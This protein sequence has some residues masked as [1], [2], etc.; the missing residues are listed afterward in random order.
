A[1]SARAHGLA[2][3]PAVEYGSARNV[4][5]FVNGRAVRD[6]SLTHAVLR[7]YGELMPHGRYPGAIVFLEVPPAALDVNVHPPQA[8]GRRAHRRAAWDAI[9]SGLTQVLARGDWIQQRQGTGAV[10]VQ[11][12]AEAIERY[13]VR[14]PATWWMPPAHGSQDA[15]TAP[16]FAPAAEPTGQP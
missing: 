4:W 2:V 1:R 14:M 12:V 8:E 10:D 5:L 16:A 15:Q 13:G 9:H 11:R 6:R 7:A 3:S